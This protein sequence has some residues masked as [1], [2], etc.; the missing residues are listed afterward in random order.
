MTCSTVT[1]DQTLDLGKIIGNS[2]LPG[3]IISLRGPL[4][5]G[6]TVIAKGIA[7]ALGIEDPITSPTFTIIQEYNGKFPMIHMDLYRIES[8][9]EFEM[10]GAEEL[11][12]ST[13]V[14]IIEWSEV[15][16]KLLPAN[17][18]RVEIS[19]EKDY[20]RSFLIS[21]VTV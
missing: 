13:N 21:G 9:E 18:I 16:D 15:I 20:S 3:S 7:L 10:L 5:S 4:G 17:T 8:I 14:T 6:K 2:C 1:A 19:L 11:L 12:F